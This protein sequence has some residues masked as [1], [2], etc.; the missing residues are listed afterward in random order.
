MDR[1]VNFFG[2]D[3]KMPSAS[4]TFFNTGGILVFIPLYDLCVIPL[5]KKCLNF[6]P[7]DLQRMGAG[8]FVAVLAMVSAVIIE[9]KRLQFYDDGKFRIELDDDDEEIE[10]VELSVWWQTFPYLFVGLSEILASIASIEFFYSQAPDS[11]RSMMG[12][13]SLLTT[14][15]A[16]YF[17]SLLLYIIDEISKS[18]GSQWIPDNLNRGHLDYY[19]ILLI[20]KDQC[21][22]GC[23]VGVGIMSLTLV[24]FVFIAV[25]YEYKEVHHRTHDHETDPVL[26]PTTGKA[27]TLHEDHPDDEDISTALLL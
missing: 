4:M 16:G 9:V 27:Y 5:L 25:K 1:K 22:F 12:A 21:L 24:V 14:S 8:Y 13:L 3:F 18:A 10:V 15:I 20:G 19:F 11:M 17:S 7:T 26:D 23:E 2:L 6:T